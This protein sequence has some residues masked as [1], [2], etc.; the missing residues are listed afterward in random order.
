MGHEKLMRQ[1]WAMGIH[2]KHLIYILKQ[3][4][5]APVRMPDGRMAYADNR[6]LLFCAQWGKC[7]VTGKEFR[8]LDEIHC[9][10]KKP[11]SFGGGDEYSNLILVVEPIHKLIH[12]READRYGSGSKEPA[13]GAFAPGAGSLLGYV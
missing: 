4:L 13:L 5:K 3:I 7:A 2:D 10:H 9:H 1:I 6:I 8:T 12:A 11:K